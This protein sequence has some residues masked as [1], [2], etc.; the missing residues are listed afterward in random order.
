[1]F[2]LYIIYLGWI[3]N[4][5]PLSESGCENCAES[6]IVNSAITCFLDI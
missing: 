5:E 3:D 4:D 1:M 2:S 6:G